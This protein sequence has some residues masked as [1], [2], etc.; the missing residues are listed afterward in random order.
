MR[1]PERLRDSPGP[2]MSGR[3]GTRAARHVLSEA[4]P[5]SA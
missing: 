5:R 4:P 3:V 2:G 1:N